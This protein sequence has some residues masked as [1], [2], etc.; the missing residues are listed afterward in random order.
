MLQLVTIVLIIAL[1]QSFA[2]GYFV[3]TIEGKSQ[4]NVFL[5]KTDSLKNS[6]HK[7]LLLDEGKDQSGY[8]LPNQLAHEHPELLFYFDR[9]A[10]PEVVIRS[11]AQI[12]TQNFSIDNMLYA[13]L[14][15]ARLIDEY[16]GLKKRS[17]AVL[18]GLDV[19]YLNQYI[20]WDKVIG[21]KSKNIND[22]LN[23]LLSQT[24]ISS[25]AGISARGGTNLKRDSPSLQF[26]QF[27]NK[28]PSFNQPFPVT[29]YQANKATNKTIP[30]DIDSEKDQPND[31]DQV[32]GPR[33][34]RYGANKSEKL[35]WPFPLLFSIFEY[36]LR[37]KMEALIYF[38]M[39]TWAIHFAIKLFK[40][41]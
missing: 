11:S 19:P 2:Q 33:R 27:V 22:N 31:N 10:I 18:E 30:R 20:D 13:N 21:D 15:I 17:Q 40:Q 6:A 8:T 37:N 41:S 7:L 25:G 39:L 35:P 4:S 24:N 36:L 28:K 34:I 1:G 3:I 26:R 23:R 16:E 14:R 9:I 12:E 29:N 32:E 38:L 5:N